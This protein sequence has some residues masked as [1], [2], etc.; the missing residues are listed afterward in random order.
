VTS[1]QAHPSSSSADQEGPPLS[2]AVQRAASVF[3]DIGRALWRGV[4]D[5][6]GSND[7]THASSIAYYALLSLFPFLLI[8]L[9]VLGA[10]TASEADRAAVLDFVLRYFPRQF[11][12]VTGQL[13]AFRSS[14]VTLGIAGT[15][16]TIWASLGVFSAV[17]TAVNYA[18]GVEKLPSYFK[19]QL[20]AFVMLGTAGL[21][22]L[23]ALLIVTAY[24]HVRALWFAE[25]AARVPFVAVVA[26]FVSRWSPTAI[27]VLVVALVFRFVPNTR[28]RFRDVWPG[29][30]ITGLV[31]RGALALFSWY[32]GDLSRFSVHGSIATVVVF[33]WWVYTTAIVFIYGVEFSAEYAR[34]RARR[35]GEAPAPERKLDPPVAGALW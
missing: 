6:Y 7:L 15:L 1:S 27:L 19:H 13:D 14:R 26:A 33:L 3:V 17:S 29:A 10:A 28:V 16:L 9:S 4:V 31:W 21:L 8:V 22:T 23:F 2:T 34:L 5:L 32:V 24:P 12:F 25:A 35:H 11:D 20:V 30:L 18:W